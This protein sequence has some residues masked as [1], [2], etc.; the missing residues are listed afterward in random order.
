MPKKCS[1]QN[2][3]LPDCRAAVGNNAD[4][5]PLIEVFGTRPDRFALLEKGVERVGLFNHDTVVEIGCA[6]G[7]GTRFLAEKYR[8]R[9][10]GVDCSVEQITA[11][12]RNTQE[13]K[14]ANASFLLASGQ[15]LPFESLSVDVVVSEAA[16]S[17]IAD[18]AQTAEEYWRVL[19]H[20][21]HVVVNDFTIRSR[22]DEGLRQQM[23]HI[24]CFAEVQSRLD[25]QTIFEAAGFTLNAVTDASKDLIKTGLWISKAYKGKPANMSGVFAKLLGV[26]CSD[27]EKR[28]DEQACRLFFRQ[29]RLGY[30]QLIFKKK[31]EN[32]IMNKAIREF[33]DLSKKRPVHIKRAKEEGKKVVEYIGNFIP[34][35][36]IYA[37]GAKPYLM[38]RGGEPEPPD[39]VLEHMLRFMNPLARSMAGYHFMGLDPVTPMADLI[40]INQTEC[41]IGRI[42][43]LLEFKGLPVYKV[44]VP[45]DWK[46]DFAAEYYY[47]ALEKFKT[48][49][50]VLTG[51]TITDENLK[52]HIDYTNTIN[53]KLR[54]IDELRKQDNPAIGG[55][56]FIHLNHYSFFVEP[57]TAIEKLEQIYEKAKDAPG[58]FADNAPRILLAGHAVAVGDYVVPKM[59]EEAGALIAA[60]MLDDGMRW[61]QWDVDTEGDLLRNIWKAKYLDKPPINIFQPAWKERF[62]YIKQLIEEYRIDAVIWYQLSFDEIYDME[63]TCISK[64]LNEMKMPFLK[65][66]SSYEYSREAMGPLS[67]RIES[68]VESVKGGKYS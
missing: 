44:G 27:T 66:E 62:E 3:F 9:V 7:A 68:F 40:A 58:A 16:F 18:K 25:Y 42:S 26:R 23:R 34:E 32:N 22:V 12:V 43:E 21:G 41:H 13:E 57:E 5:P 67:T 52:K 31:K 35:E 50:E 46:K 4:F 30:V 63:C 28:P 60:D 1:R 19:K 14:Y 8:C 24:P 29:A 33:G 61:Y 20:G 49:L 45:P 17:L 6:D 55:Y 2:R 64:W 59:I 37:S 39:T 38:C 15:N 65:L 53:E 11:A 47:K 51:N 54:K 48:K 36:L 56:E 10:L